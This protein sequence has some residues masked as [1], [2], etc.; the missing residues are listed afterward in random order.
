MAATENGVVL[1]Y[2]S[3]K[4][5]E[6]QINIIVYDLIHRDIRNARIS[7]HNFNRRY[8][9]AAFILRHMVVS[10]LVSKPLCEFPLRQPKRLTN[11]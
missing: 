1:L 2:V 3:F 6:R 10:P 8:A 11:L 7:K 5:L 4:I 9:F